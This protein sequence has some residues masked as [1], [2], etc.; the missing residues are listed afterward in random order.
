MS[1]WDGTTVRYVGLDA[2]CP[3]GNPTPVFTPGAGNNEIITSVTIYCG[4]YNATTGHFSNGW[5]CG[6]L[7]TP[8]TGTITV[9]GLA[10]L[11]AAYHNVTEQA[12]LHRVF[13][14]TIDGGEVPYLI[15]NA[16]GTD[17]HMEDLGATSTNL[18][19]TALAEQGFIL[20]YTQEMPTQNF[21]PRPLRLACYS[22]GRVYGALMEGGSGTAYRD[23]QY[24][25]ATRELAAVVWSTTADDYYDRDF[26]GV[27][28]E[29]WPLQNRK[30]TPNGEVP[31]ILDQGPAQN[32]VLIITKTGTLLLNETADGLHTWDTRSDTDGILAPE[33]YVRTPYGPMWVTQNKQIVRFNLAT[34]SLEA[35]SSDYNEILTWPGYAPIG[36][37]A[38][39]LR[40]PANQIDRYQVWRTDGSSVI[41]DFAIGGQAYEYT[42]D[43]YV[44][45]KTVLDSYG[46]IH[47]L[48]ANAS[49]FTQEGNPYSRLIPTREQA[50][51]GS[52]GEV[53]EG[54]WIGQWVD[55]GDRSVRKE[56]REIEVVGDGDES[57]ALGRSPVTLSWY[58]DFTADERIIELVKTAQDDSD[59]VAYS[60]KAKD[61]N[62]R[63]FKFRVRLAG[64]SADGFYEY[65]SAGGSLTGDLPPASYGS[66][67]EMAV[68]QN[69]SGANR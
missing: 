40:D 59:M 42:G 64:H 16:T 9:T 8:G 27:P 25:V 21:P 7:D 39:Y 48:A 44:T 43:V 55:F 33:T 14:A 28:E 4:L 46:Q 20:D 65:S 57:L 24:T 1:S 10:Y 29:A 58:G 66:V 50:A 11:T 60:G 61:G 38:D 67:F 22:N 53:P 3:S 63:L 19:L 56:F 37:C 52:F 31:L 2:Y 15:L 36:K 47:H 51:D 12:E 68:V 6:T 69:P 26:C 34:R 13:Y 45:A 41:H 18:S 17:V 5:F 32:Q 49:I 30:Y 35:L 62:R 54:D 23:F